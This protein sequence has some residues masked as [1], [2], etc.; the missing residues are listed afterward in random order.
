MLGGRSKNC[1]NFQD[2]LPTTTF[3]DNAYQNTTNNTNT[4]NNR[5]QQQQR[6]QQQ[7]QQQQE[8]Q[9]QH[10]HHHHHQQQQQ[11]QQEQQEQQDN[12]TVSLPAQKI[13]A[14]ERLLRLLSFLGLTQDFLG[15]L[16]ALL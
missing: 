14:A 1:L 11:Q 9:Q 15:I 16:Y 2:R 13:T 7:H 12:N 3:S 6:H 8:Q 10:H 5:Q 4:T